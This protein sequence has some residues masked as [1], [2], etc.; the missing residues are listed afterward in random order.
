MPQLRL[1]ID[2]NAQLIIF[3][4]DGTLIDFHAMWATWVV[5]MAQ[6]LELAAGLPLAGRLFRSLGYEPAT[7]RV[8]PGLPLALAP[9][10]EMRAA[11]V[12]S[13]RAAGL[14][15]AAAWQALD[16]AW[17]FPDPVAT[18]RPLAD[19]PALFGALRARGIRIAV[20]TA[21]NHAPAAATLAGLGVAS[22][23]DA[24]VGADDMPSKPEP[25]A[26]LAICRWLGVAPAQALVGGAALGAR[27]SLQNRIALGQ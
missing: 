1:P 9:M 12:A 19:L 3:D 7:G 13:L 4:K 6:R 20:A 22:L 23:V 8:L 25:D 18:A 10:D 21:D 2:H 17:F 15:E 11:I 27:R 5:E 26:V 16:A 24:I 14:A